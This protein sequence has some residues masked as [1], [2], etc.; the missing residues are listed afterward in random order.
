MKKEFRNLTVWG[1]GIDGELF[2]PDKKSDLL[3]KLA[4]G[5]N[6]FFLYVCRLTLKKDRQT[7]F[8]KAY[9][10]EETDCTNRLVFSI[11]GLLKNIDHQ[12]REQL[13]YNI[14]TI[15]YSYYDHI[16]GENIYEKHDSTEL[17]A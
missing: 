2:S 6:L 11:K 15:V 1:R 3:K 9:Q 12:L 17:T 7:A 8:E 5:K 16:S 10:I 4:P 13:S 14:A